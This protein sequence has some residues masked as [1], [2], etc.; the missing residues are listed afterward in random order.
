MVWYTWTLEQANVMSI[1]E[2]TRTVDA[3]SRLCQ[4][5]RLGRKTRRMVRF[6]RLPIIIYTHHVI[7]PVGLEGQTIVFMHISCIYCDVSSRGPLSFHQ[8]D[9]RQSSAWIPSCPLLHISLRS[10]SLGT[11]VILLLFRLIIIN[12]MKGGYCISVRHRLIHA[13]QE[14]SISSTPLIIHP[15]SIQLRSKSWSFFPVSQSW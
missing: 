2:L 7:N 8:T 9:R 11:Y 14:R 6:R 1:E 15:T 5:A 3:F 4:E 13:V 10:R 12:Y